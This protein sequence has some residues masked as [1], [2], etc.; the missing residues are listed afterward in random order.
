V[1]DLNKKMLFFALIKK[2]FIG[3]P[4]GEIIST[5]DSLA[6]YQRIMHLPLAKRI[7]NVSEYMTYN[8]E[9]YKN[10]NIDKINNLNLNTII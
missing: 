3:S 1:L 7:I 4:Q 5:S 9:L 6:N 10:N 2:V 8:E